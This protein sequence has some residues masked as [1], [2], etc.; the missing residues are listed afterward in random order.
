[1]IDL[2]PNFPPRRIRLNFPKTLLKIQIKICKIV[3][4]LTSF[5]VQSQ[6]STHETYL[7]KANIKKYYCCNKIL[8]ETK[9]SFISFKI[10]YVKLIS[11]LHEHE[12]ISHCTEKIH[13]QPKMSKGKKTAFFTN[14]ELAFVCKQNL[15]LTR[16]II[17]N[18]HYSDHSAADPARPL[19]LRTA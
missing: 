19:E 12:Q 3:V 14:C 10:K 18:E 11:G 2:I 17:N 9:S 1:M 5:K 16:P 13:E 7:V 4:C 8:I 6:S 15:Y